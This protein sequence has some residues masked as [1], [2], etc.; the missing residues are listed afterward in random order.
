MAEEKDKLLTFKVTGRVTVGTILT[1]SVLSPTNV[2]EFGNTVV[3]HVSK[4]PGV[5]LLLNF[6]H[7]DYLS[8]AVLTELLRIHK[9]IEESKGKLRLTAVSRTIL[10]VFE[11]TNL[12]K[13]FTIHTD[14]LDADLTRFNRALD[15]EEKESSWEPFG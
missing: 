1:S 8:S 12:N 2:I 15:V 10:E 7:V 9:S 4:N 6:E 14:G 5:N 11:I 13:M 3:E